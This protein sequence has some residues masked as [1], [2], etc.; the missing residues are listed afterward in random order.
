MKSVGR[1][2][3]SGVTLTAKSGARLYATSRGRRRE[4]E[5]QEVSGQTIHAA[6]GARQRIRLGALCEVRV[7][8]SRREQAPPKPVGG[9]FNL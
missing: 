1:D 4:G 6:K 2:H 3:S 5:I 9:P 7:S 8:G